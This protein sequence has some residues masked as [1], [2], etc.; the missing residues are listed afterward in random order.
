MGFIG[1]I[2]FL[3]ANLPTRISKPHLIQ[4]DAPV[5][6]IAPLQKWTLLSTIDDM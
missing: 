3:N 4:F 6:S 5:F 1:G 2:H